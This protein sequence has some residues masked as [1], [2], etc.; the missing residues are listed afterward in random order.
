[1]RFSENLKG[2]IAIPIQAMQRPGAPF[3]NMD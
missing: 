3:T 2:Y 1:M